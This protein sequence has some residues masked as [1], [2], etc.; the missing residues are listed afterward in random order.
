MDQLAGIH[1]VA[2]S[3]QPI[4]SQRHAGLP[5][6]LLA[7][8]RSA[9]LDR[10]LAAGADPASSAALAQR[11]VWLTRRRTRSHLAHSIRRLLDPAALRVGPSAAIRPHAGELARVRVPLSWI[12]AMLEDGEPAYSQ[13]MARLNLL[14]TQGG[15]SLYAPGRTGR[16]AEEVDAI[17]DALE[18][19]EETC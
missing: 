8:L 19:R 7:R 3:R 2:G 1:L 5:I 18:G 16:L 9:S 11:S 13:G 17:I 6:R 15:S 12:A 10:A 14:L 4:P